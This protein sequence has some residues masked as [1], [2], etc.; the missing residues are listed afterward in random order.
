MIKINIMVKKQC[1]NMIPRS[2]LEMENFQLW[3]HFYPNGKI[4][5]TI[6]IYFY[7]FFNENQANCILKD[8]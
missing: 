2:C 8:I 7:L 3:A 5:S 6:F 4:L 1:L